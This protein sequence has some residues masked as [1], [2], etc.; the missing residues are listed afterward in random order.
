M[1]AI[2]QTLPNA[3]SEVDV[4]L[5]G[6]GT[7][8]CVIAGRLAEADPNLSILIIEQGPNNLQV[9]TIVHP[10]LFMS[11]L[12]PTSN[13]TLFYQSAPEPQLNNR[14]L[15]VPSG[16]TLGGGSSINLMM[17]SR[18][19]RSDFDSWNI[20]GWSADHMIPYL[21]KQET[22]LGPGPQSVHGYDGP[23]T[24]SEGTYRANRSTR[25]FI[26]AAEQVG[27]PEIEDLAALDYNNGVQPA[28]H[29]IGQDGLRQD[30]ASRYIHPK[31]KSGKYPGLKVLVD[32]EVNRVIFEG[33]K[34]IGVEF[35]PNPKVQSNHHYSSVTARKLVIIASGALGTPLVLERSGIGNPDILEKAGIP[36]ISDLP[37]VGENYQDHHLITY[38]YYSSLGENETLDALISGRLDAGEAIQE[39]ASILGWNAQDITGKLR[40]SN[41]EVEALGPAFEEMWNAEY[42]NNTNRPLLLTALV[43]FFPADPSLV[44]VGQYLT[45]SVFTGYPLSRGSIHISGPGLDD[46]PAFT[47]GF[48]SDANDVDIL[49]HLW[50]YKKQC[51][52]FRRLKTYRGEVEIL[53]PRFAPGSRAAGG[54]LEH[55]L[56]G[57]ITNIDYTP[58]DDEIIKQWIREQV[59]TTWH[60]MGTCRLGSC[61]GDGVVDQNLSVIGVEGLKV[62]DLSIPPLNV[63]ANTMNTAVAIGEKA[64][65]IIVKELGLS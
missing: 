48:F 22:Y 40:P 10:A 9:P 3:L 5:A 8:A 11:G 12:L 50:A 24:V 41:A 32:T 57:N 64:A 23:L 62:A 18:G 47:T 19:Q 16:G 4:I 38:P 33:K 45:A 25:D 14:E 21:K 51:E 54:Y 29:Y 43:N 17:Y 35:R 59:G 6:G 63:A 55:G 15:V 2:F 52:I 7:A 27:Y 36:V 60:S 28:L 39:N 61:R 20:P 42:K 58:E 49:K 46:K 65:D 30:T 13:A 1:A 53:H 37:H 56:S 26:Q 34:A 44:P 31:I